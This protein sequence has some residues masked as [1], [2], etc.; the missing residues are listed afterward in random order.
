MKADLGNCDNW[1]GITLLSVPSKIFCR[2]LLKR[3]DKAI[4]FT[5]R[6]EQAGF[7]RGRGCV[8]QIFTLRN[9]LEQSLEWN[10]SLCINFIDFQKAF[11]SVHRT[12]LW[13]IL[14]AY[15]LRPKSVNL[16]KMFYDNFACSIIL[17]NIITEAFPVTSGAHQGCI[18][19]PVLFLVTIDWVMRQATS[20]RSRGIQWT[21]FSHLQDLD[22]ADDIAILSSTPTHLQEKSDDLTT[23]AKRKEL[24]ISRKKSKIMCVNSDASRSI[25]IE[26]EPL[27]HIEEFTYLG[28]V[29]SKDNSAQK[30]IKARLNKARCAFSRAKTSGSLSS[31]DLRLKCA[32][33]TVTLNLC[34]STALNAGEL[35][36]GT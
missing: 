28:S 4:D 36:R 5:L 17:G 2:I 34:Y 33:P 29:I 10:T 35:S 30:N 6:E 7:R 18:L 20:L 1:R 3:I 14:Q 19:S 15:G 26:G 31:I 12:C 25:N 23:N 11:D 13:R 8:D 21:I 16:I 27:E 24:I 32:S 22:F 9:I